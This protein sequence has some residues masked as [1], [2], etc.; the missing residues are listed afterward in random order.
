MEANRFVSLSDGRIFD[1][2]GMGHK[3]G[4]ASR[5]G[6]NTCD[7]GV[8]ADATLTIAAL[9]EDE[10]N[11]AFA[12]LHRDCSFGQTPDEGEWPARDAVPL[13]GGALSPFEPGG[14]WHASSARFVPEPEVTPEMVAAGIV[15]YNEPMLDTE[16]NDVIAIYRAMHALAPVP[17]VSDGEARAVRERDEARAELVRTEAKVADLYGSW[18][19]SLSEIAVLRAELARAH[20]LLA[21]RPAPVP[22]TPKPAHDP[23]NVPVRDMRRMGP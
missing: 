16:E 18:N 19:V 20:D 2:Y 23:F 8:I 5:S 17:L 13:V 7:C 4:C 10:Q 9:I 1:T 12:K 6:Q 3:P 14:Q 21:Q 22:D 15:S 11:R